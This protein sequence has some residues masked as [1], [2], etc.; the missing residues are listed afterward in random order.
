MLSQRSRLVGGVLRTL[1]TSCKLDVSHY[2]VLGITPKAT[3]TDIKTAYYE[4]SK[5]YHPDKSSV[6]TFQNTH[7]KKASSIEYLFH[8]DTVHS[9]ENN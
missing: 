2:D 3:Q 5:V 7:Q 8:K 4:L 9:E 6:S 1:S